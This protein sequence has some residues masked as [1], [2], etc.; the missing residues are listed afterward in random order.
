MKFYM[1]VTENGVNIQH[2]KYEG[3]EASS[4]CTEAMVIAQKYY[5]EKTKSVEIVMTNEQGIIIA[6]LVTKP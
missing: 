1:D 2:R 3:R 4:E 6:T 5:N